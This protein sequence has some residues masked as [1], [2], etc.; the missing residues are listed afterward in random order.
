V[1]I[2]IGGVMHKEKKKSIHKL[3]RP[4]NRSHG[5]TSAQKNKS[6]RSQNRT[7]G[8]RAVEVSEVG[9]NRTG[10]KT[11]F[12]T[13]RI[14][15]LEARNGSFEIGCSDFDESED[16]DALEEIFHPEYGGSD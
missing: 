8:L 15:D 13:S 3:T 14:E 9:V 4:I 11:P 6:V 1:A 7:V 16:I 2:T 10:F 5:K 12:D